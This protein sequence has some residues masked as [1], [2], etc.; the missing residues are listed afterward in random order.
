MKSHSAH[1]DLKGDCL[2]IANLDD[3]LDVYSLP[4]MQLMKNYSHG[5]TNDVIFKVAFVG[6]GQVISGGQ[7][8]R[9]RVYDVQSGQLLQMLEHSDGEFYCSSQQ[10]ACLKA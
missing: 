8:G 5:T 3:G 4:N 9:G 10:C 6:N 2:A 7:A 1:A